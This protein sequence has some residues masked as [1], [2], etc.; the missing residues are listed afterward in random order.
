M[1]FLYGNTDTQR[2]L[3]SKGYE[4]GMT[5]Q[6]QGIPKKSTVASVVPTAPGYREHRFALPLW[7]QLSSSVIKMMTHIIKE[8]DQWELDRA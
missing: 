6:Y 2:I 3:V 1:L 4:G 8:V 7:I 5:E